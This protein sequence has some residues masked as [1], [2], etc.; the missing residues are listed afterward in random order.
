MIGYKYINDNGFL[1]RIHHQVFLPLSMPHVDPMLS[2]AYA[3]KLV[4]KYRVH[5]I[6]WET[7]FDKLEEGEWWHI[8]KDDK[9]ELS[10]LKSNVRSKV[11]RGLKYFD[12]KR[13]DRDLII[14][15]G[16]SIYRAAYERY[17]TFETM[18]TEEEFKSAIAELPSETDFWVAS[19][20][21]TQELVGFSEN[22]VR[23]DACFYVT[24]WFNPSCLSKYLSY[25]MFHSMNKY[26]LNEQ[27]CKYVSDGARSLSHSTNIH[28]FLQSQFGFRRAYSSL[29]LV[30]D[31]KVKVVAAITYPFK[32]ILSKF[33]YGLI[34]KVN[35]LL[36]LERIRRACIGGTNG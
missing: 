2:R 28:E 30:F 32:S 13:C 16:Y 15:Q 12:V 8:I 17:E 20:I 14:N 1:W 18:Y 31:S 4:S 7:E 25:A 23:D 24:L 6:R 21:S 27:G 33:N 5:L 19:D 26:Y 35:V 9:E 36:E 11:R 10:Q 3:K 34:A 22:L 29:N